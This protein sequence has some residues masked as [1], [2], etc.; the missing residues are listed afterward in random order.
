M[1]DFI[2]AI[3]NKND[4]GLT[5]KEAKIKN[6]KNMI[7]IERIPRYFKNLILELSLFTKRC[8]NRKLKTVNKN[9]A[10]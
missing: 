6:I 2:G 8:T 10:K 7:R 4:I 3:I 5:S 9:T 1:L